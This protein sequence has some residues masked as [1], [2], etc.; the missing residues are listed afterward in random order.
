MN[1]CHVLQVKLNDVAN[2][3]GIRTSVWVAGCSHH[4]DGCQNPE[5]WKWHQ[6]V[7]LSDALIQKIISSCE[8]EYIAGLTLTGG[9]PL[10]IKN[11]EGMTEL[12]K[13]FRAK[14][15][16]IKSIWLWTG[17]TYNEIQNLEILSYL[18]VIVDGKYD[19]NLKDVS[20]TYAGSKNQRVIN[21]K[22]ING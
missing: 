16:N 5:T 15:G 8:P 12:C 2:G 1:N 11:R 3:P 6:G 14:F 13:R 18:D 7:S 10:F 22:A 21:I 19:K 20:L 17:Y 9:D 4:C